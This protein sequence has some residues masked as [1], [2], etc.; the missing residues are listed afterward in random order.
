M[1]PR[2]TVEKIIDAAKIE[3]VVGSFIQ[4]KRSGASFK[5]CCPFHEEKT[6][7]FIVTPSK[8]IYKCFG[9]G[10][11]GGAVNFVME[12]EGLSYVEALRFLAKKYNIEI[13]EEEED[14]EA[15]IKRERRESLLLVSEYAAKFFQESLEKREN[16]GVA[17]TYF[18]SR[19][20]EDDTIKN[21]GLG[22]APNSRSKFS[23]Q[24]R[25]T[26]YKEEYLIEAGLSN[27]W[28]GGVLS[29]RFYDRA[30][31]PIHDVSGRIIAF[32]G[33]T[34]RS[35]KNIAK[36]INS[37][38]TEI[39]EK[40]KV[41]YGLYFAKNEIAKKDKCIL[42]E[43][44]LD[45]ISMYQLGIKNIVSS[46]GTALTVNQIRLIRRFTKNITVIY[47]GDKA[48]INAALRGIDLILQEGL[49]VKVVLLPD[50]HDPDSFSQNHT[51]EQV[52]AFIDKHEQDFIE[53]KTDVLLADA[54]NDPIK[55]AGMINDI[56]DTIALIPDAI[57]RTLYV[58]TCSDRFGIRQ[59]DLH[60]R[61]RKTRAS[62]FKEPRPVT[63]SKDTVLEEELTIFEEPFLEPCEKEL[64]GFILEYGDHVLKFNVDSEFYIEGEQITV[65]EFI[66]GTLAADEAE[67]ANEIYRKIYKKYFT[68]LDQGFTADAIASKL[69][70]DEDENLA[71]VY[72]ALVTSDYQ[73]TVKNY[74]AALTNNDTRLV[75]YVPKAIMTYQCKK[76]ELI[77]RNLT[78][79]LNEE[80]NPE[81]QVEILTQM[82]EYNKARNLIKNVLGRVN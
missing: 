78:H 52:E 45:V 18:K 58:N 15:A 8:G 5:A 50:G 33:R 27:K 76:I 6:P 73:I 61:I 70:N 9:C 38:E 10:K 81:K 4:L 26:G 13:V 82:N 72:T 23:D 21:F 19:G 80:T 60:S 56:A 71:K 2:E 49:N 69:A 43:G 79:K 22:W 42:V 32:G 3:E 63:Y 28:E 31:F 59:E 20:L 65:A 53:F 77:L 30:I 14:P 47:D 29:D 40:N 1:I 36:Y 64:L 24:A 51:L 55:K 39:Y 75:I 12:Y 35:D 34:L 57:I 74:E 41:L 62:A 67:F 17:Y 66:D 44:Y 54:G 25:A 7:S 37:P 46:S 16:N 48:G 68:Y 11:G